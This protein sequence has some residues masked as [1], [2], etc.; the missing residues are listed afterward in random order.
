MSLCRSAPSPRAADDGQSVQSGH[1]EKVDPRTALRTRLVEMREEI[2][3][4]MVRDGFSAGRGALLAQIAAT[5]AALD[6]PQESP[7]TRG[8]AAPCPALHGRR[9]NRQ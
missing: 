3:E 9:R 7:E 4:T 5:L 2:V 6:K 8:N 1:P